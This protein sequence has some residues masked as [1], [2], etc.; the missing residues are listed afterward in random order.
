MAEAPSR[1]TSTRSSADSGM[2]LRPTLSPLNGWLAMRR[3]FRSTSVLSLPRPRRSALATPPVPEPTD[4]LLPVELWFIEMVFSTSAAVVRP[5]LT[6]SLALIVVIGSA[7]SDARRLMLE[8]VTSTRCM[9][10]SS[11]S[12]WTW[13]C[14]CME[15]ARPPA[16]IRRSARDIALSMII[17]IYSCSILGWVGFHLRPGLGSWHKR[18]EPSKHSRG[19]RTMTVQ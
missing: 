9:P 7:V 19:R 18:G 8:P 1:S 3:P 16:N 11:P 12:A 15:T 5:C 13:A 2:M 10:A 17:I 4:W 14:A 6:K